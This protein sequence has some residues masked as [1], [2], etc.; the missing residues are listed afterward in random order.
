[1]KS[2]MFLSIASSAGGD[3]PLI[4]V[5][6]TVF[7]QLILFVAT[8]FVASKL[9]FS[10]YLKLRDARTRGIDGAKTEALSFKAEAESRVAA[11]EEKLTSAKSKAQEERR[12]IK[13]QAAGQLREITDAA[14][15]QSEDALSSARKSLETESKRARDDLMPKADELANHLVEKLIGRGL[16]A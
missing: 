5:D 16:G 13:G 15:K 11:F 4:D 12:R 2:S 10:P 1:M 14:R 6:G 9:L 7:L 8:W 3:H